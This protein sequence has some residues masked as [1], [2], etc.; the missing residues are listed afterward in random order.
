MMTML[1]IKNKQ[2]KYNESVFY[3]QKT[4]KSLE[5]S[6]NAARFCAPIE[7]A[8]KISSAVWTTHETYGE[9]LVANKQTECV[10]RIS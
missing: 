9:L 8:V 6:S 3:V 5:M 1:T 2:S 7:K 10:N 4:L